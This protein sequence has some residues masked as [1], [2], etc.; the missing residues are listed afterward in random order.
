MMT[1]HQ[2]LK[3]RVRTYRI[4]PPANGSNCRVSTAGLSKLHKKADLQG[5]MIT[6]YV[7]ATIDSPLVA[8][9]EC[10][11]CTSTNED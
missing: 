2:E 4:Q 3:K 6:W 8:E 5:W 7:S 11:V 1:N 9:N 10:G